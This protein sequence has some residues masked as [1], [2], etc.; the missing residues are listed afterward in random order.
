MTVYGPFEPTS[1]IA[2]DF[3]LAKRA[4]TVA[5]GQNSS[6]AVLPRGSVLGQ[7]TVAAKTATSAV[8]A[9]GS[10]TGN[11]TF[12]LD[13]TTP[14]LAN[15]QVGV[16]TLRFTTT[17]SIRL[18]DPK[19]ETLADYAITATTGQTATTS[20]QI[21]GVVT[22]GSA[23][24]AAGDGFDIT[25]ASAIG[26][27]SSAVKAS[28]ANTGG[29]SLTLNVANPLLPNAAPGLYQVRFTSATAYS[30]TGPNGVQV[31]TGANGT[32]FANQVQFLTAASGAAFVAGDGF[33]ITV[34][35][36]ALAYVLSVE[37]ATDGSQVPACVTADDIDTSGG[38]VN[39]AAYF[40]GEFSFE[41]CNVD[42][43]WTS[44]TLLNQ[45]VNFTGRDLYFRSVGLAA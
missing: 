36:N 37:T 21:K 22:E 29:G 41:M 28:G 27:A 40:T 13:V 31:G 1:I 34:A 8:K 38:A 9:S 14:I 16:Y 4:I 5:S 26:T 30:V 33:D 15:A 3:P 6:G 19:G 45:A 23:T 39:C 2:G 24:F 18:S 12:V 7:Q 44:L 25:V 11:G 42:P 10:N 32:S 35:L 17:T 43:S 20:D